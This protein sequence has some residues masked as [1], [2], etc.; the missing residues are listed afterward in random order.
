MRLTWII[1]LTVLI[2]IWGPYIVSEAHALSAMV[3]WEKAC[4]ATDYEIR[5]VDGDTVTQFSVAGVTGGALPDPV[6]SVYSYEHQGLDPD[7]L[8]EF[9][10]VSVCSNGKKSPCSNSHSIMSN[11]IAQALDACDT[12]RLTCKETVTA[13]TALAVLQTGVGSFEFPICEGP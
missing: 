13:A 3:R 4:E 7:S 11:T 10:V 5:I 6:G 1:I 2:I 8:L 12:C 9:C